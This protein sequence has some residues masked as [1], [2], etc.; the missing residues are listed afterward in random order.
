MV[1]VVVVMVVLVVVMVVIMVM[2]DGVSGAYEWILGGY[3]SDQ[4]RNRQEQ[5][6]HACEKLAGA[7]HVWVAGAFLN[8]ALSDFQAIQIFQVMAQPTFN[9]L[10]VL[11]SHM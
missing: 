7:K 6:L 8:A 5:D 1:V 11:W 3:S 9:P 2:G 10:V 4:P